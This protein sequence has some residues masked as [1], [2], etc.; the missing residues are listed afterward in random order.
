[1]TLTGLKE[2]FRDAEQRR[3]AQ[4]VIHDRLADD[5]DQQECR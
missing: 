4:R 2:G 5:R 3:F 1:V